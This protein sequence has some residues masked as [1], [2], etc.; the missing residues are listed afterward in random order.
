MSHLES[1]SRPNALGMKA[2]TI[3]SGVLLALSLTGCLDGS[4]SYTPTS[5]S[6]WQEGDLAP[7]AEETTSPAGELV[8]VEVTRFQA[9]TAG[10]SDPFTADGPIRARYDYDFIPSEEFILGSLDLKKYNGEVCRQSST[11]EIGRLDE[12]YDA[13]RV[14]EYDAYEGPLCLNLHLTDPNWNRG[15]VEVIIETQVPAP[16]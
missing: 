13:P 8:W 6:G 7:P 2:F 9:S 5:S 4:G 16:E 14:V 3:V 15:T 11:V 10:S 12:S 1:Q